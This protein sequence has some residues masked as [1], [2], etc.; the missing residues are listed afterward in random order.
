MTA[1]V[2][3]R[4]E[5]TTERLRLRP[6]TAADAEDVHALWQDDRFVATAPPGY[7]HAYAGLET[8]IEWCT[9]GTE[10]RWQSGT[11]IEFAAEPLEGGRLI[12]HVALFGANRTTGTA[13]IH[14]WTATRARGK[15]YATEAAQAVAEW[16]LRD[17]GM[18]RIVLLA[19]V[20]NQASRQ[21]AVT[22]GFQQEGVLRSAAIRRDGNRTD[23]ALYS[24]IRADLA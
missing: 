22:A 9:T 18:A 19:A 14:Y 2:F 20:D 24:L 23:M 17:G 16:A 21:V 11:T 12:G 13:E 15:G 7:R 1:E 4:E 6:F 8:A 3:P 10:S 5:L